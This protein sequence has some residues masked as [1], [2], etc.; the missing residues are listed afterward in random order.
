MGLRSETRAG[1]LAAPGTPLS[2]LIGASPEA[3]GPKHKVSGHQLLRHR[4]SKP[5]RTDE[6]AESRGPN[7]PEGSRSSRSKAR[8][9]VPGLGHFPGEFLLPATPDGSE[10]YSPFLPLERGPRV[11]KRQEGLRP[12]K[13]GS[14]GP[15]AGSPGRQ[16]FITWAE[17]AAGSIDQL[18]RALGFLMEQFLCKDI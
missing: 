11:G 6:K 2:L 8:A 12:G 18:Q 7:L 17:G 13:A 15:T 16:Q 9:L 4:L 3:P 14:S 5:H 1:H 10:I